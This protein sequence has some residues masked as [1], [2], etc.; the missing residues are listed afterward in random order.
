VRYR[1]Q[2]TDERLTLARLSEIAAVRRRFGY[3][4][5]RILPKREGVV[6]NHKRLRPLYTEERLQVRRRDGP[7]RALGTRAP[8]ALPQA[9]NQRWSLDFLHDQ[10]SDGSRCRRLHPRVPGAG[11]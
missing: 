5:L 8:L 11:R 9:P 3:R 1:S 2:R 7:K 10:L 6:L 4:R